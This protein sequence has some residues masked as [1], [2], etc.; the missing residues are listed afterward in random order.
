[1]IDLNKHIHQ[2]DFTTFSGAKHTTFFDVG[3][4]KIESEKEI[5][6]V[7]TEILT[8]EWVNDYT[9]PKNITVVKGSAIESFEIRRSLSKKDYK[10]I[11]E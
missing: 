2:V 5:Y 10:K 4:K 9:N 8:G 7:A 3:D 1:M 6:E 11:S